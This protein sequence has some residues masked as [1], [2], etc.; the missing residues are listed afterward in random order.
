M[1]GGG[2]TG[3]NVR[4]EG[5]GGCRE[6]LPSSRAHPGPRDSLGKSSVSIIRT[7]MKGL[8]LG[9]GPGI[10]GGP[11]EWSEPPQPLLGILLSEVCGAEV[12]KPSLN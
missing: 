7:P 6:P 5:A 4:P 2:R 3:Q 12:A 9:S 10:L 1:L 8:G 11:L